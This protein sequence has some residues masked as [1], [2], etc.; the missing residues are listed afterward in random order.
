[1]NRAVLLLGLGVVAAVPILWGAP[2]LQIAGLGALTATTAAIG[3]GLRFGRLSV[4]QADLL[5]AGGLALNILGG[6]VLHLAFAGWTLLVVLNGVIFLSQL[7][8][9]ARRDMPT[10]AAFALFLPRTLAGPAVGYRSFARRLRAGLA[11]PWSA[12]RAETGAICLVVGLA[13][14]LILGRALGRYIAPVFAAA[15]AGSA[16]GGTD[17]W[18][19]TV[20]NYLELYF[21]LSGACDVAGGLLLLIGVSLPPAFLAPLRASSLA[22]FWRRFH[23]PLVAF[24]TV[25]LHRPLRL[26]GRVSSPMAGLAAFVC[27]GLWFSPGL[28]GLAWGLLQATALLADREA[29]RLLPASRWP[30]WL[31]T[32]LF[33]AATAVL[34]HVSSLAAAGRIFEGL[35]GRTGFALPL[36]AVNFFSPAWQKHLVFTDQ[37]LIA[38]HA[39]GLIVTLLLLAIAVVALAVPPLHIA[40]RAWRRVYF[41]AAIYFVLGLSLQIDA[42]PIS[43]SGLRF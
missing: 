34:L 19:A 12:A 39:I 10:F 36:A 2:A 21:E 5:Y 8:A 15:E 9:G 13:K 18:L 28:G 24:A 17:A 42:V 16:V 33:M 41:V 3:W 25:Y 4:R 23:R 26:G 40:S 43:F 7:R 14:W 35:V 29:R 22:S 32:Q 20:A 11:A 6:I 31:A 37:P 27:A 38:G 30:G 1:M